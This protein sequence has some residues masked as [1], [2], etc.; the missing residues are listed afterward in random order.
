M[1]QQTNLALKKL[2][3]I[4]PKGVKPRLEITNLEYLLDV[5]K[6]VIDRVHNRKT[7]ADKDFYK[8]L[9]TTN[10]IEKC[11]AFREI[12]SLW[13]NEYFA[14]NS[15]SET[16]LEAYVLTRS[17]DYDLN[18][19]NSV[20]A[21]IYSGCLLSRLTKQNVEINKPT[22]ITIFGGGH[23]FDY[24]FFFAKN[25]DK[26]FVDGFQGT[27]LCAYISYGGTLNLLSLTNCEG[28]GTAESIQPER[29]NP[30]LFVLVNH[31]GDYGARTQRLLN[32]GLFV[33]YNCKGE[34]TPEVCPYADYDLIAERIDKTIDNGFIANP[35]EHSNKKILASGELFT[36]AQLTKAISK[37]SPDKIVDLAN[38]IYNINKQRCER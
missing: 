35:H 27:N 22:E 5:E 24:L 7:E 36:I 4:K 16:D 25:V 3:G 19:T 34:W 26:L 32:G 31:K 12:L 9:V 21:G 1:T 13:L 18:P 20:L 6:R 15:F 38:K 14:D 2:Q 10:T 8:K 11:T 33:S 29:G 30:K 23:K 17:A 28:N 37:S